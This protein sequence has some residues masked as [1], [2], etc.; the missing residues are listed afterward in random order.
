MTTTSNEYGYSRLH[1]LSMDTTV[2]C[3]KE[4]QRE[5]QRKILQARYLAE[6]KR[7]A[8]ECVRKYGLLLEAEAAHAEMPQAE[9]QP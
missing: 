7:A 1:Q 2:D 3:W 4:R 9:E 6:R 8:D 5:A